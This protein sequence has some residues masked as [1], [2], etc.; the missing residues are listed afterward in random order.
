[1]GEG[2]QYLDLVVLGILAGFVLYRLA[3]VLGR[4]TGHER[5]RF[6]PYGGAKQGPDGKTTSSDDNVVSMPGRAKPAQ[7]AEERLASY[8]PAGSDLARGLTEI[9][10]ADRGFDV[11]GFLAGARMAYEMIVNAFAKGDT[12]SLKP[13]LHED[14]YRGFADEIALREKRGERIETSFVGLRS[15]DLTDAKLVNRRAELTVR[16]V[17]ELISC[18]KNVDGAVIEGDPTTV[19]EVRDLW[20]FAR[21]V[22]SGD[23]NWQLIA[24]EP[25]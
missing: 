24:T 1:M 11:G 13:L 20:T 2:F 23:P 22:R 6:N 15:S 3:A 19:K 10:L 8:A 4:R 5:E 16:F 21:D 18:K 17:S 12:R 9:Q 25:A 14:V 7:V